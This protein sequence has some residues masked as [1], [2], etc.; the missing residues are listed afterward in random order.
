MAD[1]EKWNYR[2]LNITK[3]L[4]AQVKNILKVKDSLLSLSCKREKCP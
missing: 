4:T 2:D 3:Q 1:E